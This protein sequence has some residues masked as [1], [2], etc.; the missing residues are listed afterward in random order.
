MQF[1]EFQN[2]KYTS[3]WVMPALSSGDFLF[4][5]A[6]YQVITHSS[7]ICSL[8]VENSQWDQTVCILDHYY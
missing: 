2:H 8:G 1:Y 3:E 7:T 6:T 4:E 5:I